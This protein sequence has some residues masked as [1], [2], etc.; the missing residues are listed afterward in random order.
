MK[1]MGSKRL[2]LENGLGSLIESHAEHATR[3][4][5]PFCGSGAVAWF[6][7]QRTCRKVI[8]SDLQTYAVAI[9]SAVVSRS[10]ALVAENIAASWLSRAQQKLASSPVHAAALQHY[11]ADPSP[12]PVGYVAE[13]RELCQSQNNGSCVWNAYGGHYYSPLQALKLDVLHETL[14]E[15]EPSRKV[16][17]ASLLFAAS[18]CSAAPGHTAQPFQATDRAMPHLLAA[19][20]KDP[21]ESCIKALK[22]ICPRFSMV[23]GEAFVADI[24]DLVPKMEETDLVFFDPPYSAVQYSRFYHVLKHYA[25]IVQSCRRYR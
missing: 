11:R 6:A 10:E 19:W 1:Y 18:N 25:R 2:M 12:N 24:F 16:A 8:A 15:D 9:A 13:A 21:F 3:I 14:P 4:L 22:E 23:P 5:D 20:T 17:L 7:A